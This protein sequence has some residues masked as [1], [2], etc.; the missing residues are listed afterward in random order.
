MRR[1][2]RAYLIY[3]ASLLGL[4]GLG[5]F[6]GWWRMHLNF[7]EGESSSTGGGHGSSFWGTGSGGGGFRGGK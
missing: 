5:G 6:R 3:G 2:L 1:S 7:G 4:Y